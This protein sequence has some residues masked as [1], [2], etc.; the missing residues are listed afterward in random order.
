MGDDSNGRRIG[1]WPAAVALA[2][3]VAIYIFARK[4]DPAPIVAAASTTSEPTSAQTIAP[5]N[6]PTPNAPTMVASGPSAP[7]TIVAPPPDPDEGVEKPGPPPADASMYDPN[8]PLPDGNTRGRSWQLDEKLS[9]TRESLKTM[10]LRAQGLEKE[11]ADAE[12]AGRK[13]EASEKKVIL[14][15]LRARQAELQRSLEA[16]VDP[17]TPIQ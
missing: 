15:R 4:K 9:K 12:A 11:I 3:I 7:A 5:T 17:T 2:L 14:A 16:G 10:D 8:G 13:D 1:W 6:A